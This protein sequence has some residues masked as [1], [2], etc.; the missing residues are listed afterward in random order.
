MDVELARLEEQV[1]R[2]VADDGV[3][4]L[5]LGLALVAMGAG[6]A[7]RQQLL[8][9]IVPLVA[10]GLRPLLTKALTSRTDYVRFQPRRASRL[11]LAAWLVPVV[12]LATLA[13]LLAAGPRLHD[14]VKAALLIAIPVAIAAHVLERPR[15]YL[16][17]AAVVASVA[18]VVLLQTRWER[19]LLV[20]GAIILAT[21]T[22]VFVR[23]LR[24][25]PAVAEDR[26]V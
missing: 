12:A 25:Y 24:R 5:L 9:L 1:Y 15:L 4:D 16:Y 17:A 26:H 8:G 19:A 11:R 2:R 7:L 13:V 6:I 23:F 21:G 20:S 22:F 18:G 3:W 14:L 10:L